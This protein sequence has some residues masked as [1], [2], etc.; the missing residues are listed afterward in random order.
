MTTT[1]SRVAPI[2]GGSTVTDL[3]HNAARASALPV[4][5][6]TATSPAMTSTRSTASASSTGR[7]EHKVRSEAK[8]LSAGSNLNP[9]RSAGSIRRSFA[10][11]VASRGNAG[12]SAPAARSRVTVLAL[13]IMALALLAF[14]PMS[15]AKTVVKAFGLPG[16]L[17]GQFGTEPG[18][19]AINNSGAGG[20]PIGTVYIADAN[21]NRIQRFSPTGVFE[22]TWGFDVDSTTPSTGFEICTAASGDVCKAGITT[23]TTANGGQLS[24]P[25]SVAV[26]QTTGHVYVSEATGRRIDEFDADGNFVR[27]WGWDVITTG[28]P[29]DKGTA[30][31]EVCDTTAG[32]VAADCKAAGAAVTATSQAA[33]QFGANPGPLTLDSSGNVWV[34]D[35]GT[36]A[37]IQEFSST[38]QFLKLVGGDVITDGAEGT[39]TL[40]NAS[41]SV[42]AVAL[43]KKFF[44]IGQAVSGT[45]IQAGTTITAVGAFTTPANS[46]I[47]LSKAANAGGVQTITA[48]AG[49]GNVPTNEKQTISYGA[50]TPEPGSKFALTFNNKITGASGTAK[51]FP[52]NKTIT[53]VATTNGEFK[54]GMNIGVV[55]SA[56][57]E[58][59]RNTTI[60][61]MTATTIT[62]SNALGGQS[63]SPGGTVTITGYDL[64]YNAPAS[65]VESHLNA[66]PSVGAAGGSV[67]VTGPNGGPWV[68]E[69]K[70]TRYADSDVPAIVP[71]T[72]GLFAG[73]GQPTLSVTS[74]NGWEVCSVAAECRIA[75][76]GTGLGQFASASPGDLA[77]D[78]A[79]NLYAIDTG[80]KRVQ[81]FNS[82]LTSVETFG[83]SA[84][85]GFT[86]VAPE[87]L[88]ATQGGNR[89]LFGV[90]NNLSGNERQLVELD[91]SGAAKETSLVGSGLTSIKGVA[92]NTTTG[93]V[94]ATT[95]TPTPSPRS[96]LMLTSTPLSAPTSTMNPV[97]TKASTT[98]TFSGTTNPNGGMVT[99]KYQYSTDQ[100]TWIDVAVPSCTTLADEGGAQTL[101]QEVTGLAPNTHYF[102]RFAVSRTLVANST[103][104]SAVKSFN[105]D[106]V[107]PLVT[108]V[109]MLDLNNTSVR[110]VGQIDARHS[111]TGYVF[112][113]GTT[114]SLTSQTAA[115]AIG[116]GV[117]PVVVSQLIENL[118]P[119]TTYYYKL[120]AENLIGSTSSVTKTFTTLAAPVPNPE[121]RKYEMMSPP[122]K[123][124]GGIFTTSSAHMA[125]VATSG[126]GVATC[127]TSLFGEPASVQ[128]NYCAPLVIQRTSAGW[129]THAAS[130]YICQ[131]G[132]APPAT[133]PFEIKNVFS[134]DLKSSFLTM[135]EPEGCSIP[136]LVPGTPNG[137]NWYR[138]DYETG[139]YEFIRSGSP[140]FQTISAISPD[141]K[142]VY[143]KSSENLAPGA[144]GSNEKLYEWYAG[145]TTLVSKDPSGVQLSAAS[146]E[147]AGP[148]RGVITV[149]GGPGL[150]GDPSR[151]FFM[152]PYSSYP[153]ANQEVYMRE[154]GT[155]TVDISKSECTSPP[156]CG[157]D[158]G[159][160]DVG[161]TFDGAK[162]FISSGEKLTDEDTSGNAARDL[163]EYRNGPNPD[164]EA[165][166]LVLMTPDQEPE[167]GLGANFVTLL[168]KSDDGN[169]AFFVAE[170]QIVSNAPTA[171]KF[172][173]YRWRWNGGSPTVDYLGALNGTPIPTPEGNVEADER[174]WRAEG[175]NRLVSRN[176]KYLV[177]ATLERLDPAVDTDS[178]RDVYRWDEQGGWRCVSCQKPG[179]ASSGDVFFFNTAAGG[180]GAT[181][182]NFVTTNER[183]VMTEDGRVFFASKDALVPA[184]INTPLLDVYEWNEGKVS[185][186]STGTA[187][188]DTTLL[189][190]GE[191]GDDVI[192]VTDQK[193]VGWDVDKNSDFYDARVGG[194][195][196]EPSPTGS[197]C[198]GDACRDAGSKA[199]AASPAGTAAF[200]GPGNETKK[201]TP[202]PTS[203]K[204]GF[205][206]RHSKCVKKPQKKRHAE[207]THR[208]HSTQK[209][210]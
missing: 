138:T 90:N 83:A 97:N 54:V 26:N 2:R 102:V 199:P 82:A 149:A 91:T 183:I 176:G 32:N 65:E 154:N 36:T 9:S 207:K 40:T 12:S 38:G 19:V 73:A 60:V 16:A 53:N 182:K 141:S 196:P 105:T 10:T 56:K 39:G 78:S 24:K 30:A 25:S 4:P 133:Y 165:H 55:A 193:L 197:P 122:D 33:G 79:G 70:G 140:S 61:S 161:S 153:A 44:E 85:A 202:K 81:K 185:L 137:T 15:Q 57:D 134:A 71:S 92:E 172:K 114:P 72:G 195:F 46:T 157:V 189:G 68:V 115:V 101:S 93:A 50:I 143:Y 203:C 192:F 148:A 48:P 3:A 112:K 13:A 95:T 11:R 111:P 155:T 163:Y 99:C 51:G 52:G 27:L 151:V 22:R 42:T 164:A 129:K 170:G 175:A 58:V 89:L 186:I 201:T 47:T 145:T 1:P 66:L 108:N 37:R 171:G 43:T 139:T 62:L 144:S 49:V 18:G 131:H 177:L 34:A 158:S 128:N 126:E 75:S 125:D 80:N 28:K 109:G 35:S 123:N 167:D 188:N 127:T 178:D 156:P 67:S 31:F 8:D 118:S 191:S 21:Q 59:P 159:A 14:A 110:L 69:F 136:H 146:V 132:T 210:R 76:T 77:F 7:N 23:A 86:T 204:K 117:S 150:A 29:N 200:E 147:L 198:E 173:V 88:V 63:I 152:A 130:P 180:V 160:T 64:S 190:A 205:V 119:N 194:G 181:A 187:E 98:A 41:T 169:T 184:D 166:N 5:A 120:V 20:V 6:T 96:V 104:I 162:V 208:R 179:V 209:G 17:G 94:Y 103:V 107:P 174:N 206:K 45:G 168:G 121:S 87:R 100:V 106:G 124:F 142:H 113:Y 84:L 116:E 74:A 135:V